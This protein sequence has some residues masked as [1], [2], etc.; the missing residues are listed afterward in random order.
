MRD[1]H[2]AIIDDGVNEGYYGPLYLEHNIVITENLEAVE[3]QE[4]DSWKFSHGTVCAGIINKY[5]S[6]A[7]LSSIKVLNDNMRGSIERLIYAIEWCIDKDVDIINLSIGTVHSKDKK[8]LR[9]IIDKASGKDLIIAAAKSNEDIETY[10]ACFHNV[11]GIKSD[12]NNILEEGQ[13]IYNIEP[14]DGIEITAC[15]R[16]KLVNYLGEVK[17]TPNWNSYAVPMISAI[18]ADMMKEHEK[19]SLAEIKEKLWRRYN[20]ISKP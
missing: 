4:Y 11:L 13:F 15:A 3:R 14:E 7:K 6:N 17:I 18:I 19:L 2:I 9:K 20:N 12:K 16:H 10:P 8:I 1:V 5:C